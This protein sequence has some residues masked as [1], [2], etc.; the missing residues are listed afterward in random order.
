MVETLGR[1]PGSP[2]IG[3]GEM[4]SGQARASIMGRPAANGWLY[5]LGFRGGS[6]G[7]GTPT[8]RLGAY[9]ASGGSVGNKVAETAGFST[10]ALMVDAYSGQDYGAAPTAAAKVYSSQDLALAV[11]FTGAGGAHGQDHSGHVMHERNGLASLPSPFGSTNSRPEG[12]MSIWALIQENRPPNTPGVISPTDG[13]TTSDATPVLSASFS[14]PDETLPGFSVGSADTMSAWRLEVWNTAKTVRLRDSGKNPSTSGERS[15]RSASWEVMTALGAGTYVARATFWDQFDT[16][17]PSRDWTFTV[18]AGGS[19]SDAQ[20]YASDVVASN[21]TNATDPRMVGTW[22]H[23]GG[24]NAD[25][26]Q[27]VLHDQNGAAVQGPSGEQTINLAPGAS[28]VQSIGG[29]G[30]VALTPGARYRLGMRMRDTTGLWS[31]WSYT[32]V[33]TVNS[34]PGIPI[35]LDPAHGSV[36]QVPPVVSAVIPDATQDTSTL[37]SEVAVRLQGDTGSGVL[38]PN[39][40]RSFSSGKHRAELSTAELTLKAIWEW[41]I[42][43]TDPYGLVGA[44]SSWTS[45]TYADPPIVTITD[46]TPAQVLDAGAPS[47]AFTSSLAMATSRLV[48]VEAENGVQLYDSG[49]VATA[50]SSGAR[51][52]PPGLLRNGHSYEATIH[53][54][55]TLGLEGTASTDFSI[56]YTAPP[57][58]ERVVVE[59]MRG[60]LELEGDPAEWSRLLIEWDEATVE[61][62]PDEVFRGYILRRVDL[63]ADEEMVLAFYPSRSSTLFID[64]T[65]LSGRAYRYEITYLVERNVVDRVESVLAS[66]IGSVSLKHAVVASLDSEDVGFPIRYWEERA[67][68]HIRDQAIVQTFGERPISFVGPAASRRIT[69]SARIKDNA[70]FL[71]AEVVEAAV[72]AS[73]PVRDEEGRY[74]PRVMYWRDPR[75]RG[76]TAIQGPPVERDRHQRSK[77]ELELAYTEIDASIEATIY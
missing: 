60:P 70:E 75:G 1:K 76:M 14:D 12:K 26:Y 67:V 27:I 57:A 7:A 16:P 15:A 4:L 19:V 54:V 66:D 52:V 40:R 55:S 6:Q 28:Q 41:R 23:S 24:L 69:V 17:S 29:V 49:Y 21:L 53:V 47:V 74:R 20:L 50:G 31:G 72:E 13:S 77:A 56:L 10:P 46:P 48:V 42:R 32:P 34:A 39:A 43:G 5:Y 9:L 37:T 51:S 18:N 64:K 71:A 68:E 22:T 36:G 65:P 3:Y 45:F 35:E 2:D 73:R 33:F 59:P 30:G 58:I 62:A 63:S 11:L 38:I 44:W 25:R 61:Q 8:A